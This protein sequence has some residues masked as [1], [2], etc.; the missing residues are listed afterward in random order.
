MSRP[1]LRRQLFHPRYW[2]TWVGFGLWY[3]LALL[4]YRLQCRLGRGLGWL[5]YRFALR[6]RQIARCNLDLCFPDWPESKREAVTRE[7]M[8]SVG[9]AFFETGIAW[10][11]PKSRLQR[12]Y[13]LEGLEHLQAA[14]QAGVGVLLMAFHFTHIDIGAKLLGLSFSI[15]GSYR[16]HNNPVYD[17]IQRSGRERHSMGG[18]AF[19][20]EDVRGMVKALRNGRAIWYA[21]DQ[22]Y[23]PKHSIF[24]PLFG[25]PAATVTAT[26]QLARLG[27]AQVIAFT[28]TRRADGGGY[29][30]KVYPPLEHFPSGD[31]V[32]DTLRINQFVE[33]RIREQPEQ[34][35]WVHRRFKSRPEGE[36]DLYS[37]AGVMAKKR[38]LD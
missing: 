12:L 36:P 23:G 16:P 21:P 31:E 27:K 35:L 4:P 38:H 10:F 22:D 18:Q 11:W 8:A 1:H 24:V 7:I 30:L 34:Y 28:Q 13:S 19:P 2:L 29:H 25:I 9:I 3:A 14:Q 37:L 33:A 17:Y 15:D 26:S 6:R 5:L 20:R 32:A